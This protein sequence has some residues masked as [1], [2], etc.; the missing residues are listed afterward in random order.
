MTTIR[1]VDAAQLNKIKC[2]FADIFTKAP[3]N[4]DWSDEQQLTYYITDLIGNRNSLSLGLYVNDMLVGLSLGYIMHWYSGTE[5]Y[6]FEFCISTEMQGKG[7][8]S[9]FLHLTEEYAKKQGITHIFLQTE[10]TVPAYHFYQKNGF[11]EL[12]DHTSLF[13]DI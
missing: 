7:L 1:P 3:W 5:Y 8:G 6:I 12:N 9:E 2:L 10:R 13:K 11:I 4:D